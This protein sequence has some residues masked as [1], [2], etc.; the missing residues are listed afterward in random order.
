ME[1]TVEVK[2]LQELRANEF[3]MD[4]LLLIAYHRL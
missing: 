1:K 4:H 3:I 2:G